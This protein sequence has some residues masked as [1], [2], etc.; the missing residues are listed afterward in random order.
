MNRFPPLAAARAGGAPLLETPEYKVHA[1]RRTEPELIEVHEYE[2]DVVYVIEGEASFVTG[3]RLLDGKVTAPGEIRGTRLEGGSVQQLKPG[4]VVVVPRGTP[5]W[6]KEIQQA[7]FLYFVVKSTALP[8][9][10][11][12]HLRQ[13]HPGPSGMTRDGFCIGIGVPAGPG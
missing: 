13:D 2:T 7:P 3:G 8:G 1:S 5:Y 11:S 12:W 6:F 9:G 10:A 4:D